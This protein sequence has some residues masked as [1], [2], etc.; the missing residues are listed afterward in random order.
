MQFS[1]C[2][3]YFPSLNFKYISPFSGTLDL[4]FLPSRW[5]AKFNI[6]TEKKTT[7]LHISMLRPWEVKRLCKVNAFARAKLLKLGY[8]KYQSLQHICCECQWTAGSCPGKVHEELVPTPC[9]QVCLHWDTGR[10][11]SDAPSLQGEASHS[12]PYTR[13]HSTD[14][15][16][17]HSF[18]VPLQMVASC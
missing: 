7:S 18:Y 4:Y 17:L 10:S 16:C 13:P 1:P 11:S 15:T 6:H 8:W 5:K 14:G 3:C 12:A 2:F 9:M